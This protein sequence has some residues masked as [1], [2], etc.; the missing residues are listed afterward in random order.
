MYL[1]ISLTSSFLLEQG[2][3]QKNGET[4]ES[5]KY[6]SNYETFNEREYNEITG[7]LVSVIPPKLFYDS[8]IINETR[9][10]A[11]LAFPAS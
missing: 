11:L 7:S 10:E 8:S 5:K 1:I 9:I 4:I 6:S 3:C 2:Y